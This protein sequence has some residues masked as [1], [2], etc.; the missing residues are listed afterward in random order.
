MGIN[1]PFMDNRR[2]NYRIILKD[3]EMGIKLFHI[4][5]YDVGYRAIYD[6]SFNIIDLYYQQE[7]LDKFLDC[8]LDHKKI[9]FAFLNV[10]MGNPSLRETI[11]N[12]TGKSYEDMT[13]EE[14]DNYLNLHRMINI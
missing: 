6:Q 4:L 5:D 7:E 11:N 3:T 1:K 13:F 2:S 9:V 12:A 10:Y 8:S 14:M